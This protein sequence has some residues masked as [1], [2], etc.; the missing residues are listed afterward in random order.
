MS[1]VSTTKKHTV[2]APRY[3]FNAATNMLLDIQVGTYTYDEQTRALR[4]I[5]P[6][7][8]QSRQ[9]L[10]CLVAG[11]GALVPKEVLQERLWGARVM[12]AYTVSTVI[13]HLRQALKAID[14]YGQSIVTVPKAGFVFRPDR[15]G[16]FLVNLPEYPLNAK[17]RLCSWGDESR[18]EC[19]HCSR[20]YSPF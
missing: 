15:A 6:L 3:Y 14:A 19:A 12:S 4:L 7:K 13:Y 1:T 16:L 17:T 2:D 18:D 20:L 9:A 11:E 8:H 5:A 10:S